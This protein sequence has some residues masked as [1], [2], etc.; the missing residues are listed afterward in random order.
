MSLNGKARPACF[1]HEFSLRNAQNIR[2]LSDSML[3]QIHHELAKYHEMGRFCERDE[4]ADMTAALFHEQCAAELGV[5]EAIVTLASIYLG[6]PHELLVN[7][8][9]EESCIDVNK[10]V[11]YMLMAAQAGDRSAMLYVARAF[12]TGLGLG[13]TRSKSYQEAVAWYEAAVNM[14]E[15]DET[16]EFDATMDS[17]VYELKAK[18]ADLYLDGGF[19]LEKDASYAGDLYSE[20]AEAA[21]GAM[22]GRLASK[23]YILAEEAYAQVPDD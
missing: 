10:G 3:G 23:Y 2:R 6:L 1:E 12:E 7:V 9:I 21:T 19:G 16:G 18:I 15:E 11:D 22:K 14:L 20:A 8:F 5:K 13:D 4:E 17:P